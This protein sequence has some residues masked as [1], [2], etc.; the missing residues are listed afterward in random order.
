M[1]NSGE[2]IFNGRRIR[3]AIG[4]LTYSLTHILRC[5]FSFGVRPKNKHQPENRKWKS[6]RFAFDRTQ[7]AGNWFQCP[8][9]CWMQY[10]S[11]RGN[12][13]NY[14]TSSHLFLGSH[15]FIRIARNMYHISWLSEEPQRMARRRLTWN[16]CVCTLDGHTDKSQIASIYWTQ[17]E[18]T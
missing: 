17:S 15:H 11:I 10:F 5:S 13:L 2:K 18:H 9:L 4:S 3:S 14:T 6:I 1:R 7:L 16:S 8:T 12:V